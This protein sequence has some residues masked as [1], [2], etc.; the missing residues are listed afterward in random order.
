MCIRDRDIYSIL[1]N[2]QLDE[3]ICMLEHLK[4]QGI[5]S[6]FHYVPLHSSPAGQKYCRTNKGMDVTGDLSNRFLR[7]PMYYEMKDIGGSRVV[8]VIRNIY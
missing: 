7:L 2:G 3:R 8:E 4:N 6:V 1:S 5:L